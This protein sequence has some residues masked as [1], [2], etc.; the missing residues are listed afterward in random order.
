MVG[1]V[2]EN[3]EC[4]A[5][6]H[7]LID[8]YDCQNHGSLEEIQAVLIEAS[9]ATGATV[10]FSHLHPFDG[11][12]VSGVVIL[13]ESHLTCHSWYDEKFISLDIFVCGT[14]DPYKA[15]PVLQTHFMPGH[16]SVVLQKRGTEFS[17]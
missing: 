7:L 17:R 2:K 9:K 13:A 6:K 8:L 3:G 1:F 10:L 4:Y 15:V 11:G 16:S 12:G 5:G 14:C